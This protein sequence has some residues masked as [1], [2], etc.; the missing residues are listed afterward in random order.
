VTRFHPIRSIRRALTAP[1]RARFDAIDRRLAEIASALDGGLTTTPATALSRVDVSHHNAASTPPS[2]DNVVSQVVSA[3][4]FSHPTFERLRRIMFPAR[5]TLQWG[6]S[7]AQVD[8]LH[9]KLWEFVYVLRAAEQFG[10]L[11]QGRRALGFGVGREPIPATL[12]RH[13]LTVVATDLDTSAQE[14]AVWA[15]SGQHME[16]IRALSHPEIVSDEIL[17]HQVSTRYVD[18]TDI[19]NDLG[20]FDLI[21]SC[22]ALEHL[23]SPE[24]GLEF[25]RS[26]LGLL[27]PGGVSVHTTELELTPREQTADYGHLAVY[28]K[29]DLDAFAARV[30]ALGFKIETNWHVSL[31]TPA[32]RWIAL[33]P[34]PH[35]DPAHLKL[36]IGESVSTSVGLLVRRPG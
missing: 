17:E 32:D 1:L 5:V 26:T 2:F 30:R 35:T 24:A 6:A 7:D 33:P 3:A 14:S 36:V 34:Y 16:G 29:E 21:W 9:R 20:T 28:R 23:G 11:E 22:C 4:Q 15:E 19:P 18:M 31:D 8:V 12:A 27:E 25:V 13:G 10:N